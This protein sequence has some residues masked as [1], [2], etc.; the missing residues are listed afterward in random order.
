MTPALP[1]RTRRM[2]GSAAASVAANAGPLG[3]AGVGLLAFLAIYGPAAL[4]PTRLGWLIRDD[5]SQH[6][7][8]WLFFRNEPWRFPL[9]AID[10]YLHPLGTTLGYMDAI[11]WVA[12]LLRP[13]SGL[14]P[15]DFQY[16]GP[17]MCACLML[18]GA[19]AAWVARRTGATVAQQ[20]LVGA[21][22]VLSPTLLARMSMAHE[23]LCAHWT[24]ILLVGLHLAPQRD[25]RDAK[26]A[27]GI[28]LALCV[29]AAGVHP[30]IAAMVLALAL[31]LCARTALERKLPWRWPVLGAVVHVGSVLVLFYVLG[32]LGTVRTLGAGS[33]GGFSADL[34]A[35][36]NPLG[37]Q[38]DFSWSRFLSPLPRQGAQ[39]EGFGYLGLGVLFALWAA[40]V[41][42]VRDAP[43][44]ARHWRRWVP[45]ALVALGLFFFALS[46]RVTLRGELIADL[47]RLYAPVMR[48]VE[49][50]R[51]SGRFVWPLYYLLALGAAL[52]LIRLPKPTV[53]P[54]LLALALALQ[55]FD[56]NLGRGHQ[57]KEGPA[58]NTQPSDALRELA[59][60]REHLVLYP[61][62]M[63]D[64]SGRGC[65]AGPMDFHRWAYR[66]Y[67]LGLTFNSG[68]V[69]RL[70]DAR[71]QSY[72][73]G[74]DDD[75]R[76]GRLDPRTVYLSIP[77]RLHEFR[78]IRGTRCVQ[79]ER[80]W[81]CVLEQAP[82]PPVERAAP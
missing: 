70:D 43:L 58:W 26:Q 6:L 8:G 21:L 40:L 57:A 59:V 2:L 23:A 55:A 15:A 46:S 37:Y 71:A 67:R 64:G 53:A 47:T 16:I 18:Q 7:L 17:W 82:A 1:E 61:P 5:F 33:F 14:L 69:A 52:A 66:A 50:F 30:V 24:L 20:W 72:C 60:G 78:A 49:P 44:V 31:S 77:Q 75:I 65:R 56:V 51:S 76:A 11:P 29:F 81:M 74:L 45:V 32:Y 54:S 28:A 12:L 3:A 68:Y 34:L 27:L 80:L 22:L 9:G 73:L 19:S 41:L 48:W 36:V 4:D 42:V 25:A 79:E 62:Q 13:F 10:G 39:Y 38:R 63:H 35:F